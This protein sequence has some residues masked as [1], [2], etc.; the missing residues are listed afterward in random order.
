VLTWL[1]TLPKGA[2]VAIG[3]DLLNVQTAWPVGM[4]TVRPLGGGLHELRSTAA[5]GEYRVL[6]CVAGRTLYALHGFQKKT[7]KT[8]PTELE[9]ARRRQKDV[10]P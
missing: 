4:P 2:R 10:T 7:Q 3:A 5:T 1:R 6:F 9:T 8:P